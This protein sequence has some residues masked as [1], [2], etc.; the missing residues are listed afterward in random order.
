MG[1]DVSSVR[2]LVIKSRGHFRAGFDEFYA[3]ENILEVDAPGLTTPVLERLG[4]S[5]APRPFYP[6]D[7]DMSWRAPT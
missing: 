4:L 3:P 7:P 6:L 1:I 5:R 2:T